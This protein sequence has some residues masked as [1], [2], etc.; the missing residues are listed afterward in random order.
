[1]N[2]VEPAEVAGLL[3]R[4]TGVARPG[5]LRRDEPAYPVDREGKIGEDQSQQAVPALAH[6]Y[7]LLCTRSIE[8]YVEAVD[9]LL[10]QPDLVVSPAVW[11]VFLRR[12]RELAPA[13]GNVWRADDGTDA[14]L[15]E[16]GGGLGAPVHTHIINDERLAL[17]ELLA[18]VVRQE[19][20][21]AVVARLV[22]LRHGAVQMQYANAV[23]GV[24]D[25]PEQA[26]TETEALD[27][28][29]RHLADS[30]GG[31]RT[32]RKGLVQ[33]GEQRG[34]LLRML[35]LADVGHHG[36]DAPD[37]A[38]GWLV[39]R[40]GHVD[41][42]RATVSVTGLG[43]VLDDSTGE[44]S[45]DVR[46]NPAPGFRA[47]DFLERASDHLIALQAEPA[48]VLLVAPDI[49]AIGS[50]IRYECRQPVTD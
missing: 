40:V 34:F 42:A 4:L 35:A 25:L 38:V 6:P 50:D 7:G 29:R 14:E 48:R 37:P 1:M 49:A 31:G 26:P 21:D 33:V 28:L 5:R 44:G 45:L 23:A 8:L 3:E 2:G 32:Q 43:F 30:V 15:L 18:F 22:R 41:P 12:Q 24:V 19:I 36:N 39:G 20:R 27:Q 10:Q 11:R 47:E 17:G 16:P 46:A 9:D 13:F